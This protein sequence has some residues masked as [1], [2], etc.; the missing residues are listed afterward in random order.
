MERTKGTE[1]AATSSLRSFILSTYITVLCMQEK[2]FLRCQD[3]HGRNE[4]VSADSRCIVIP[5]A[6]TPARAARQRGGQAPRPLALRGDF[7]IANPQ[8]STTT[9]TL[10]HSA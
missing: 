7:L 2:S 6:S 1:E 4:V 8:P 9:L 10:R 5:L 3:G